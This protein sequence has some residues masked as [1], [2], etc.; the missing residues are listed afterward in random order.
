L[1][2]HVIV[3]LLA[4]ANTINI[5]ADLGAMGDALRLLMGG[6]TIAYVVVFGSI[7]AFLQVF[8]PYSVRISPL[9]IEI[10]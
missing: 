5:G 8:V 9:P 4:I 6:P 3:F 2:L 1:V 10:R 7:C